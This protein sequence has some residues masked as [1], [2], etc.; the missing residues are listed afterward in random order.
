MAF[1]KT[2]VSF[3]RRETKDLCLAWGLISLAFA[4]VFAGGLSF[5]RGFL[6]TLFLA[7]LTVGVGFLVHE[8]AHKAVALSYGCEAGFRANKGMLFL[9]VAM[10]FLGFVFAA[11]GAVWFKGQTTREQRGRIAAAGPSANL[12]LALLFLPFLFLFPVV[13][14]LGAWVNAFLALFNL[15]PLPGFDGSAVLAWD[16]KAYAALLVAA[17]VLSFT[18]HIY[19]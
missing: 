4:V 1:R 19:I 9:A 16:K 7:A 11:P 3:S 10:S 18:T 13:G 17:C 5:T 12:V 6:V 15:L 2:V 14:G 8:L